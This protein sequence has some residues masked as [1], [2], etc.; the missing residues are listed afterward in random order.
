M[1]FKGDV[2]TLKD[3]GLGSGLLNPWN[4]PQYFLDEKGESAISS[5]TLA[6]AA[7]ILHAVFVTGKNPKIDRINYLLHSSRSVDVRELTIQ[8]ELEE[9]QKEKKQPLIRRLIL[10]QIRDPHYQLEPTEWPVSAGDVGLP[11]IGKS[12]SDVFAAWVGSDE[13]CLEKKVSPYRY[14]KGTTSNKS[15]NTFLVLD[16]ETFSESSDEKATAIVAYLKSGQSEEKEVQVVRCEL[17]AT[18]RLMTFMDAEIGPI[19]LNYVKENVASKDGILRFKDYDGWAGPGGWGEKE[20]LAGK[21]PMAGFKAGLKDNVS[22][23]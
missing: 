5:A 2:R 3:K 13:A 1:A 10:P 14:V 7:C 23:F 21:G 6:S 4:G 22:A 19:D 9:A 16:D 17:A 12:F 20:V 15:T 11:F 8:E 18:L